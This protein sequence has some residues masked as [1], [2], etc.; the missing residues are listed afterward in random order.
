MFQKNIFKK[1]FKS[2]KKDKNVSQFYILQN[3]ISLFM[4]YF[5]YI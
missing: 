4:V 1:I 3:K 2:E 5:S